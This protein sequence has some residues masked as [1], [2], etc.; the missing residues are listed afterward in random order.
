MVNDTTYR[1]F[2]QANRLSFS[3]TDKKRHSFRLF[4]SC[5]TVSM[6]YLLR[7]RTS[8]LF[9]V[10]ALYYVPASLAHLPKLS[11]AL[12]Q[13]RFFLTL[14]R[15]R[16]FHG[17]ERAQYPA[18]QK[19]DRDPHPQADPGSCRSH[20]LKH[21]DHQHLQSGRH[22]FCGPDL[23]QRFRRGRRRFQ[24][25]GHYSGSGLYA[26]PRLR[27]HHQ[28]QSGQQE[29]QSSHPVRFHQ[30]F[31][32]TGRWCGAGPHRP[33]HAARLH[34]AAGQHR[35][36]PAPRLRLCAAHHHRGPADDL[37]PRDE[38]HPALRG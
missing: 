12:L 36:H 20:D 30:L 18:I 7:C 19:N 16:P 4:F 28:P 38:Q 3:K 23:H 29:H 26:G 35:D 14:Y 13:G 5:S 24:P 10:H 17:I 15:G 11:A 37:Q 9:A 34:A 33:C 1:D 6:R 22:L 25:D 8:R 27:H 32:G 21:A 2:P 31:H